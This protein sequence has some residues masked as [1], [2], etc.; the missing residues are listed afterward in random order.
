VDAAL[1]EANVG[2][3]TAVLH[4]FA[5]ESQFIL[6]THRQRTIAS[7]DVLLGVTMAE[8]GVSTPYAVRVEDWVEPERQAA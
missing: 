8:A 7:C 4:E 2:R 5:A 3:F 1:D 6:I